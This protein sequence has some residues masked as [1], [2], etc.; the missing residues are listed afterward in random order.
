MKREP[1]VSH[2][3]KCFAVMEIATVPA[4][5]FGMIVE[6]HSAAALEIQLV[7]EMRCFEIIPA[8]AGRGKSRIGGRFSCRIIHYE[9]LSNP[10]PSI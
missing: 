6:D 10:S 5:N 1:C 7:Q 4:L 3:I 2:C 9:T 8:Q